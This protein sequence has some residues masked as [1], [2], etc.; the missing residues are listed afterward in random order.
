[1]LIPH[2]GIHFLSPQIIGVTAMYAY[3]AKTEA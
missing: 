3:H 1:M 2:G